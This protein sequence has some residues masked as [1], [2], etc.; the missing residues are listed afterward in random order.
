VLAVALAAVVLVWH[1]WGDTNI[2]VLLG[3]CTS[4]AT[5]VF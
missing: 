5:G 2:P 3:M 4:A 1:C